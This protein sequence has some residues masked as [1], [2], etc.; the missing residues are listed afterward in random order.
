MRHL[1]LVHLYLYI[2]SAS[3]ISCGTGFFPWDQGYAEFCASCPSGVTSC[4]IDPITGILTQDAPFLDSSGAE[5][6][7]S[8][9][10]GP[11]YSPFYC[12]QI[13]L[14]GPFGQGDSVVKLIEDVPFH[15]EAVVSVRLWALDKWDGNQLTLTIS[16]TSDSVS[17]QFDTLTDPDAFHFCQSS[18][19]KDMYY[20]LS[21]TLS[22]TGTDIT[23]TFSTDLS[24]SEG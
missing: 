6:S 4:S 15:F 14:Y 5:Y 22:S 10:T 20:D 23:I 24:D 2:V 13:Q 8:G 18:D 9:F 21:A 3:A 19:Y 1:Y 17:Y 16:S 7:D 11:A 12:D